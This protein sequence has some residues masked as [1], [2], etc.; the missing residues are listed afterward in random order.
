MVQFEAALQTL[1]QLESQYSTLVAESAAAER[2]R[3]ARIAQ[4][5]AEVDALRATS[6]ALQGEQAS[7]VSMEK[8]PVSLQHTHCMPSDDVANC[9]VAGLL[10]E[11][12]PRKV[13]AG[14]CWRGVMSGTSV[15][16][17]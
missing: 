14:P 15:V 13:I 4:L 12:H 9:S 16:G 7:V 10:G 1:Q 8:M 5:E 17:P 3:G 11:V 2:S 6:A